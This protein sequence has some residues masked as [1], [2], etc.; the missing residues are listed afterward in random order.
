MIS[1]YDHIRELRAELHGCIT[2][3]EQAVINRDLKR[4]S[5]QNNKEINCGV[6]RVLVCP[7]CNHRGETNDTPSKVWR[8]RFRCIECGQLADG[9]MVHWEG[10]RPKNR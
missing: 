10:R 7:K 2:K 3:R 4:A 6:W 9:R 1:L 5:A 8:A